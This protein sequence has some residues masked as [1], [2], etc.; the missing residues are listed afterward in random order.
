MPITVPGQLQA[1]ELIKSRKGAF[2][3]RGKRQ[4]AASLMLTSLIDVFSILVI[5]LLQNFSATG[6]M[7]FMSKEIRLPRATKAK[8]ILRAPVITV[9]PINITL[10]GKKV[11]ENVPSGSLSGENWLLQKLENEL[12]VMRKNHELLHN[13]ATMASVINIQADENLPF[14]VIKRVMHSATVAGFTDINFAVLKTTEKN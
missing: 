3:R 6:E 2:V 8:E 11:G 7:L 10:E 9:S 4:V 1:G 12:I 13:G 5:F 14:I